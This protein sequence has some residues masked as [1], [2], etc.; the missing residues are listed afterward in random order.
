M[1]PDLTLKSGIY[2]PKAE[3]ADTANRSC[4]KAGILENPSDRSIEPPRAA[5]LNL[6]HDVNDTDDCAPNEGI[7]ARSSDAPR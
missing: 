3:P 1:Q 7:L 5:P 6:P 2:L 4:E